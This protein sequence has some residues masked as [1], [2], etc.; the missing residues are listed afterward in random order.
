MR[1]RPTPTSRRSQA[2]SPA[3]SGTDRDSLVYG[4]RPQRLG[5]NAAVR[6]QLSSTPPRTRLLPDISEVA[7]ITANVKQSLPP[8]QQDGAIVMASNALKPLRCAIYTRKST[9]HGLDQE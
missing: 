8:F 9:E 4:P 7:A 5:P 6:P 1:A 3:P 2:S